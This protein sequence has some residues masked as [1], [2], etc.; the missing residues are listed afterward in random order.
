M[1]SPLPRPFLTRH[2]DTDWTDSR[3]RTGR[4]DLPPNERGEERVLDSGAINC[5]G[6]RSRAFSPLQRASSF[7]SLLALDRLEI[8]SGPSGV[9]LRV[10]AARRDFA[11]TSWS[12]ADATGTEAVK[13]AARMQ[14]A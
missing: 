5:V 13:G 1:S 11:R 12:T 6:S 3:W 2:G 4:T 9:G 7:V 8:S 14:M 10:D